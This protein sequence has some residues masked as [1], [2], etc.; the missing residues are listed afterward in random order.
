MKCK[1]ITIESL[2]PVM[3]EVTQVLK[4]ILE[5]HQTDDEIDALTVFLRTLLNIVNHLFSYL[6]PEEQK[7]ILMACGTWFDVGFMVGRNPEKLVEI[8][9][10]VNPAV[11]GV[12]LP[13]WMWHMMGWSHD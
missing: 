2:K 12:E 11:E 6:P 9:D 10:K 4:P 7:H 5:A 3:E 1:A 13:D 8:L